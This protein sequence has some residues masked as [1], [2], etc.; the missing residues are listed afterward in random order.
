M[1]NNTKKLNIKEALNLCGYNNNIKKNLIIFL[2]SNYGNQKN[3]LYLFERNKNVPKLFL[4]LL[5]IP[6]KYNNN[7]YDI[8]ILIYFPLNFPLVKPDIYFHKYSNFKINPNCINYIDE[9]T[10]RL[11]YEKF[12]KWEN[13]LE[14]FKILIKEIY[15]QFNINFPIFTFGNKNNSN[16]EEGDCILKEQC[17]KEIE[18][19]KQI[20]NNLQNNYQKSLKIQNNNKIKIID[21]PDINN[22]NLMKKEIINFNNVNN[23]NII[24]QKNEE[25]F[26]KMKRT[27][28]KTNRNNN[29]SNNNIIH[30][31][32][33]SEPYDEEKAKELLIKLLV[34]NLYPKIDKINISV[35]K[36]KNNL[37]KMKNDILLELKEFEDIEKKRENVEKSMNL[38]KNE[39]NKYK[40]PIQSDKY[41]DENKKDFSNLDSLLNIKNKKYYNLLSKERVIEEYILVI[42]KSYEKHN[43]ELSAAMNL[44]RNYSRQI[45][46]IK[47][48]SKNIRLNKKI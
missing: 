24:I 27:N 12:F 17:C 37:E 38:L 28:T 15:K 10:L 33:E 42:K 25:I 34:S 41:F 2:Q 29:L 14:S 26:D 8:S 11:N 5:K 13:S 40:N 35:I 43:I 7:I 6:S 32:D 30:E 22:N 45:F 4:L 44:V 31:F 39:L 20:N 3:K 36:T 19:R 46:Y 1:S 47:Y 18:L 48:K 21:S 16:D 23:F 9:E